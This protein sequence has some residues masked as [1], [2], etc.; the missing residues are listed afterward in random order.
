MRRSNKVSKSLTAAVGVMLAGCLVQP[1]CAQSG[2]EFTDLQG[3]S[4]ETP[5][6]KNI[7]S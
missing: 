4:M 2:P 7:V 6:I 3:Y 1:V 5:A